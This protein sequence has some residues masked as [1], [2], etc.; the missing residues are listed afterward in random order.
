MWCF[1]MV[2]SGQVVRAAKNLTDVKATRWNQVAVQQDPSALSRP[3][4][5]FHSMH[6]QACMPQ[7]HACM[8]NLYTMQ[9]HM[10]HAPCMHSTMHIHVCILVTY[11]NPQRWIHSGTKVCEI[12]QRVKCSYC[13]MLTKPKPFIWVQVLSHT[14]QAQA[15]LPSATIVSCSLSLILSYKCNYC[16]ILNKPNPFS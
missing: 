16:L 9:K 7:K 8:H 3:W 15:F 1:M 12:N 14:H 4:S 2:V 5:P 6:M 10:C 13:L 11:V